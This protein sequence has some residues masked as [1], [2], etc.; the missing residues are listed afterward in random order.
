MNIGQDDIIK[1]TNDE[2]Y[3]SL[4][5]VIAITEDAVAVFRDD[6]EVWYPMAEYTIER[7]SS[8]N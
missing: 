6:G 1:I 4:G 5:R 3:V 8:L 2:G 7:L